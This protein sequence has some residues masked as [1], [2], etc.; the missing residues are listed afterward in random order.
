MALPYVENV[1]AI[2]ALLQR[3]HERVPD[4]L[5][6]DSI[7]AA[8]FKDS[9]YGNVN[10]LL[11]F[12][13]FYRPGS[14]VGPQLVSPF[15]RDWYYGRDDYRENLGWMLKQ[16]YGFIYERSAN[17]LQPTKAE[18]TNAIAA[19]RY[20]DESQRDDTSKIVDT[21]LALNRE[22]NVAGADRTLGRM[23]YDEVAYGVSPREQPSFSSLL[24]NIK[25]AWWIIGALVLLWLLTRCQLDAARGL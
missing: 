19:T 1:E 25:P 2:P 12:L 16:K 4:Q 15:W 9:E 11:Y 13:S 5:Y 22:A 14:P 10:G 17:R 8:G 18:A 7:T 23:T 20:I 21:F 3:L 6:R 24:N